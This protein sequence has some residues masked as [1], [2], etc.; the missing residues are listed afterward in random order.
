MAIT[1][2]IRRLQMKRN[3]TQVARVAKKA[4]EATSRVKAKADSQRVSGSVVN[5]S[6]AQQLTAAARKAAKG[7]DRP[8]RADLPSV[9]EKLRAQ[10]K[11]PPAPDDL[12]KV[13]YEPTP[14]EVL[15]ELVETAQLEM[16][17]PTDAD[18]VPDADTVLGGEYQPG[19]LSPEELAEIDRLNPKAKNVAGGQPVRKASGKQ[20]RRN[21]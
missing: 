1:D 6:F 19:D 3:S 16:P 11:L 21:R 13:K 7:R 20:R 2:E 5:Q 14:E 8:A 15:G 17:A 4:R 9:I 18:P 10:G 12:S